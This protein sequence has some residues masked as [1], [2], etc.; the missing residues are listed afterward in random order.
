MNQP[1]TEEI[2]VS[3]RNNEI[4]SHSNCQQTSMATFDKLLSFLQQQGALLTE[5]TNEVKRLE[6]MCT[7]HKINYTIKEKTDSKIK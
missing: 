3:L 4:I 5:K 6:E 7:K 2:I 1:S